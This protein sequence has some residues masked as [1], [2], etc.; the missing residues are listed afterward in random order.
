MNF[1]MADSEEARDTSDTAAFDKPFDTHKSKMS[2]IVGGEQNQNMNEYKRALPE[3][4]KQEL[5]FKTIAELVHDYFAD[6][7]DGHVCQLDKEVPKY[8]YYKGNKFQIDFSLLDVLHRHVMAVKAEDGLSVE[9]ALRHFT[10]VGG[11]HFDPDHGHEHLGN[12]HMMTNLKKEAQ[13]I[14]VQ[15][16]TH[17]FSRLVEG[18]R[19]QK[20][21]GE[22]PDDFTDEELLA[23][24]GDGHL[25]N[26]S[27]APSRHAPKRI[28]HL[29]EE[30]E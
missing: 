11:S 13:T 19:R 6:G 10:Q 18:M 23:M 16:S 14:R 20:P 5:R 7:A 9:D 27:M 26:L 30:I 2:K 29:D 8:Y 12:R 4:E 25:G 22:E 1:E 17:I 28:E 21:E 3:F 15:E 24:V